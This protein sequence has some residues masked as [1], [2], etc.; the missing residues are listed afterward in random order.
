MPYSSS[1][2]ASAPRTKY[3]SPASEERRSSRLNAAMHVDRQRLQLE[4]DVER[5]QV[6]GGR[7]HHHADRAE[8]DQHG[9]L[10]PVDAGLHVVVDRQ[11]QAQPGARQD[12]QL[13]EHGEA[14]DREQP[15]IADAERRR[16]RQ[17]GGQ[18]ERAEAEHG[19]GERRVA[20]FPQHAEHQDRHGAAAP[21]RS[22]AG[23]GSSSGSWRHPGQPAWSPPAR[24][25]MVHHRAHARVE[26]LRE[27]ARID[28]HP[29]RQHDQ[30]REDATSRGDRSRIDRRSS[31]V[32]AP[33]MIR[34]YSHS[35]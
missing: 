7:H 1:P 22:R 8:Q 29:E 32:I 9:E 27:A 26:E 13:G 28:A 20:A 10:E 11:H 18:H 25:V 15:G 24:P 2:D 33:K 31:R 17:H 35:A 21:A 34:R 19:A 30:R 14:V 23:R 12:Q 16:H 6:G 3:F 5:H 4:P